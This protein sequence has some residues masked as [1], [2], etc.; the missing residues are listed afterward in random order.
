MDTETKK[1]LIAAYKEKKNI[2]G[3]YLIKNAKNGKALLLTAPDIQGAQN[4]YNFSRK[5]SSCVHPKL[6]ADWGN[7]GDFSMEI[8]DTLEKKADTGR[9]EFAEELKDLA[10]IWQEKLA[11]QLWY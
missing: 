4:R 8:L 1:E 3:V 5:T 6:Q 2:G 10:E 7:G 11:D 9:K